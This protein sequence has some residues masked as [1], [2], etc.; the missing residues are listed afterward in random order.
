MATYIEVSSVGQTSVTIGTF[1]VVSAGYVEWQ[2]SVDPNFAFCVCPIFRIALA[3]STTFAALNQRCTYF[4]RA[5]VAGELDWS[6]VVAFR[7]TD[8]PA[9]SLAPSP[10]MIEP[11]MLFTPEPVMD[12]SGTFTVAGFPES[13][14][15]RD[16]PVGWKSVVPG[17]NHN[18]ELQLT[19]APVDTLA[20][21]NTNM[22]EAST[23]VLYAAPTIEDLDSG[24]RVKLLDNVPFRASPNL[25]GRRGYHGLF[26]FPLTAGPF[27]RIL[28]LGTKTANT[29]YVEHLLFGRN[30]VTKNHSVD[31]AETPSTKTT[32]ERTRSG[33]PDR[34]AGIPMRKVEFDISM[35]TEA[36]YE[37]SYGDL[38]YHENKPVFVLPN[39][40][41]GAFRHDRMLYG[42][43]IGSKIY[44]P[45]SPRYTRTFGV[46][47]L[48]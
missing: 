23:I 11:A 6:N 41:S 38:V 3:S 26:S 19:G 28:F 4:A 21:L 8:G 48:I 5:R 25:P 7:T 37:A 18:L 24:A 46:D 17:N 13:N 30:R 35:L 40:K 31:K 34:V 32:V 47:S 45:A 12:W 20:I 1:G 43:L 22:P 36:Q 42:D 10:V 33:I 29:L 15:G 14:L 16:A 9:Q 27:F 39:S 44:N 2:F